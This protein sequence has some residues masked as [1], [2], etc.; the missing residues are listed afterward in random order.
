MSYGKR[1]QNSEGW[2]DNMQGFTSPATFQQNRLA[3]ESFFI[4]LVHSGSAERLR[5]KAISQAKQ[6]QKEAQEKAD[7]GGLWGAVTGAIG[8]GISGFVT[9]GPAGALIGAASGG[10]SGF[11]TGRATGDPMQGAL[12]GAAQ[13]GLAGFEEK[14]RAQ[15]LEMAAAQQGVQYKVLG[16]AEK[17]SLGL[18][19]SKAYQ[20]SAEGKVSQI[21]GSGVNVNVDQ[22]PQFGTIP[23]GQQL[24]EENG[25]FRLEDIPGGPQAK[26]TAQLIKKTT[27]QKALK[28]RAGEVVL[29]DIGRL[30][31]KIQD[32]PFFRP[33][34]GLWASKIL[35]ELNQGRIDAQALSQ[36]IRS[37]VG[38]DR[39]QQMRE[40]SPT[41][42]ALGQVSDRELSTLQAVLGSLE[43]EQ[44]E[45]QLISNLDR[46]SGLYKGIMEKASAYPNAAE[47]GFGGTLEPVS[48]QS[49]DNSIMDIFNSIKGR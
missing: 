6:E 48:V 9:G 10:I 47:F 40:A 39:L 41:G 31:E 14:Q 26:K 2:W 8:G 32:A 7:K 29:K 21:G 36:T 12:I 16:E 30:K 23:S 43:L 17:K 28:R 44:S 4:D 24:I 33:I 18:D 27:E 15:T 45:K 25:S 22:G 19:I 38:F 5:Q 11:Q 20:M 3:R 1:I 13:G 46:L 35:P 49:I 42:G 34:A 37:N